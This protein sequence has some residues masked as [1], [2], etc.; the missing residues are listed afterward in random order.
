MYKIL[1]ILFLLALAA[2]VYFYRNEPEDKNLLKLKKICR[3]D[4]ALAERLV[5]RELKKAPNI[6]LDAA[7]KRAIDSYKRDQ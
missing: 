7:I 5:N 4:D 2:S 1:F 3:G 6:T